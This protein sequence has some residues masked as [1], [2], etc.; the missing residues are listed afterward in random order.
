MKSQRVLCLVHETLVPP[1]R[2]NTTEDFHDQPWR[3]E[4]YVSDA[5][6]R[7][8]H[9]VKMCGVQ[10][11]L[12]V[13]RTAIEEFKPDLIFNLLEEFHGQPLYDQNVVSY[14]ELVPVPYT[15]CNP[16]GMI[17]AR[18]KA[19]A[20]KILSYHRIPGP[21]FAVYPRGSRKKSRG[22]LAFPLLVK[23]QM[24]EASL[25]IS[26]KSVVQTDEELASRISLMHER[27]KTGVI[28]EEYISGRELYVGIF[29]DQR[30]VVFPIWELVLDNLP[31]HTPHIATRRVKWNRE[32]QERYKIFSK[33]A[34]GLS[35]ALEDVIY[36]V[37]KR[38]YRALGLSGYARIDM[39]LTNDERVFVIEA[40]PNPEIADGEDFADAAECY[41][42]DYDALINRL[43]LQGIRRRM[44]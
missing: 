32:Y 36:T 12:S 9:T 6:E 43:V 33:R 11:D 18:D 25:G 14:L 5:L 1:E 22:K 15:G 28:A 24:E 37:A 10:Y 41:G 42:W 2:T 21:N 13:V 30:L 23:S 27:Y 16:R 7:L 38:T 34:E 20:R 35:A 3:T 4:R 40:N 26:Q 17:L 8:G 39:R 44:L 19:L 29:G 31:E